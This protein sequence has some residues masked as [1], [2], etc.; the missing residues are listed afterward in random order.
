MNHWLLDW[1]R[2]V[3]VCEYTHR[4]VCGIYVYLWYICIMCIYILYTPNR[5]LI[6]IH[7]FNNLIALIQTVH[8][9]I[10]YLSAIYIYM[11]G[12]RAAIYVYIWTGTEQQCIYMNRNRAAMYIWTETEQQCIYEQEQ[13][14]N[15]YMNRNRAA[16]YIYEQNRAAMNIWTGTGSNVYMN[17]NR[18]AMYIYKQE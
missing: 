11:N 12:N 13:S 10:L 9:D 17:R 18:A 15:V 7:T 3:N 8:L 6:G 1:S 14:S 5:S 2:C 16:M 4:A